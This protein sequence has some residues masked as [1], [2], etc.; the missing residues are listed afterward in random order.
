MSGMLLGFIAKEL[1]TFKRDMLFIR[2]K[3]EEDLPDVNIKDLQAMY[4]DQLRQVKLVYILDFELKTIPWDVITALFPHVKVLTLKGNNIT[5][6]NMSDHPLTN[7]THLNLSNNRINSIDG[8]TSA[9]I[10]LPSLETLELVSNCLSTISLPSMDLKELIL[11]RNKISSIT[12][13]TMPFLETLDL[14][15]NHLVDLDDTMFLRLPSLQQLN[16]SYNRIKSIPLT[17]EEAISM[18][19]IMHVDLSN[20]EMENIP[21]NI[22]MCPKLTELNLTSNNIRYLPGEI[23]FASQ[24]R[25]LLVETKSL[26]EETRPDLITTALKHEIPSL[27]NRSLNSVIKLNQQFYDE[28]LPC[29]INHLLTSTRLCSLCG[30]SFC[31]QGL[32]VQRKMYD[33]YIRSEATL[34][35]S[36][37]EESIIQRPIHLD[38]CAE[39][40]NAMYLDKTHNSK[41]FL[42][43]RLID[44]SRM[45]SGSQLVYFNEMMG[46]LMEGENHIRLGYTPLLS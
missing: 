39:C 2:Y 31:E 16:L 5:E 9:R 30:E 6:F 38:I 44:R 3:K 19:F 24:L 23:V 26:M 8:L 13:D 40:H 45:T 10:F 25:W 42:P 1:A 27:R 11:S 35:D 33:A 18:E 37:V 34:S 32:L 4:A 7:L 41:V 20:N 21:R 15:D 22:F 28:N 43:K 46:T 36:E 29:H 12:L 14:S 17:H